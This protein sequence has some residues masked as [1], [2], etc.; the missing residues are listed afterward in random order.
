MHAE[1]PDD[2]RARLREAEEGVRARDNFL[3][4]AAHELRSPLN[5]LALRLAALERLAAA[6]NEQRLRT[7]IEKTRRM[8]DRY[9]RRAVVLLDASRLQ[10]T[11]LEPARTRVYLAEVVHEVVE[12][13]SDEA[14]FRGVALDAEVEGDPQGWWDRHM[15]EQILANLVSN[16]IKYG[17]GSPVHVRACSGTAGTA[18]LEVSDEG[19]GIAPA[20]RARVFEKF[21]RVVATAGTQAGFGLG[22]WI[23]GRMV[24]AH[25]GSIEVEPGPRGGSLFRVILPVASENPSSKDDRK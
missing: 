13:H 3:A 20:H 10:A 23:V 12:A 11:D 19:P 1:H 9:V 4:V 18:C 6:C 7:E 2:L 17:G 8:V 16:A 5:A 15:V 25:R 21:E 22:L 14:A 24:A